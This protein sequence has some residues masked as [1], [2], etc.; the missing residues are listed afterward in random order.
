MS[1][2]EVRIVAGGSPDPAVA[3]AI[4]SAV[5]RV[6]RSREASRPARTVS[7]WT[8]AARLEAVGAATV[9]SRAA[10]PPA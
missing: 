10:L 3:A 6:M 9:R 8:Q 5:E 4:E 1:S 7:G 2:I